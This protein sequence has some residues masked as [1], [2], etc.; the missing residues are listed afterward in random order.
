M[1]DPAET[2]TAARKKV[3]FATT[4]DS[5]VASNLQLAKTVRAGILVITT[6]AV[7]SMVWQGFTIFSMRS[8]LAE[9]RVMLQLVLERLAQHH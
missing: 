5:L 9:M 2:E 3:A 6:C 8:T 4:F 1:P 7:M